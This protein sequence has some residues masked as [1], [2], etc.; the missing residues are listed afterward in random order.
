MGRVYLFCGLLAFAVALATAF[1][2]SRALTPRAAT[3]EAGGPKGGADQATLAP[4]ELRWAKEVGDGYLR[5]A[6]LDFFSG[7]ALAWATPRFRD[8]LTTRDPNASKVVYFHYSSWE[9]T[10]REVSPGRDEVLFKGTVAATFKGRQAPGGD[11]SGG[12]L[13]QT[14]TVPFTLRVVNAEGDRWRVDAMQF[15]GPEAS[16]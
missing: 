8:R 12:S 7:E 10:A 11:G 1:V 5:A 9:V 15:E 4:D 3:G 16:P 6:G 13:G 2:T 14:T